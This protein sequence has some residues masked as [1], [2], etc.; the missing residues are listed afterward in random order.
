MM[1]KGVFLC[2]IPLLTEE[3]SHMV[4]NIWEW[5]ACLMRVPN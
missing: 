1:I 3:E 2:F 5:G 4:E